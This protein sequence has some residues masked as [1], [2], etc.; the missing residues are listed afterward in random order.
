MPSVS[1]QK[2]RLVGSREKANTFLCIVNR[3]SYFLLSGG[4]CIVHATRILSSLSRSLCMSE[5]MKANAITATSTE[6]MSGCHAL[7]MRAEEISLS[8]LQIAEICRR[9]GSDG[10]SKDIAIPL[11]L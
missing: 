9:A 2:G 6:F 3:Q 8:K 5:K 11:T 1:T 7:I 10:N 4:I